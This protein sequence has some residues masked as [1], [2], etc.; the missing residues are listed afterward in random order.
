MSKDMKKILTIALCALLAAGFNASAQ[1]LT[2]LHVNDTH[3]HLDPERSGDY[4]GHGGVI[5]RAAYIDSL[6]Q[7]KGK[8]NVL[9]LHAGDW[10]QGSSYFN[11]MG[12]KLEIELVNALG[13]DC[14]TLGNHE[15]DNGLDDLADRVSKLNM[16]VVCANYDFSS[17]RLGQ[18]IK[19]YT[20][21]KRGGK[22]IGIVGMLCNI[23]S[24]VDVKVASQVPHLDDVEVLNKWADYLKNQEKCDIVICLSHLGYDGDL[25]MTEKARNVDIYIGGHSHTRV[26]G[27]EY[28]KDLDGR[29]IPTI[30]D[31][32]YGIEI[33]R[34]DVD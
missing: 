2:I 6:R 11:V 14:L 21:V 26:A 31:Y 28:R 32:R 1:K 12:G 3:S 18:Y 27:F 8:K 30:Q 25:R 9:L 17:F 19:P 4:A 16:P 33:G 7:A 22:K 13:Y 29:D 15:F 5:E 23:M 24:V 34:I 20:I 10:N